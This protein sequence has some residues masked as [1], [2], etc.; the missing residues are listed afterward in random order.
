MF[1]NTL[2]SS[3][4][5]CIVNEYQIKYLKDLGE[6]YSSQIYLSFQVNKGLPDL[7]NSAFKLFSQAN[8]RI[9]YPNLMRIGISPSSFNV[10]MAKNGELQ[11]IGS[12]H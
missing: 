10:A 3:K 12:C 2:I 4:I 11:M 1:V 7:S 5:Y 9:E 8:E 6:F